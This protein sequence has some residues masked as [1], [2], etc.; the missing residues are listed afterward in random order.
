MC[1]LTFLMVTPVGNAAWPDRADEISK[2]V[3]ISAEPGI[4]K[5]TIFR[6]VAAYER[7]LAL[8]SKL[9]Q[10]FGLKLSQKQK[11]SVNKS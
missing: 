6:G 1:A 9:P 2:V 10:R 3:G 11:G 7:F 4:E 8:L 5:R